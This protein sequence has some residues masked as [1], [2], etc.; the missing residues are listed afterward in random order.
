M[1]SSAASRV[2]GKLRNRIAATRARVTLAIHAELV[3][4]NPVDT[5]H[6]RASWVPSL[7]APAGAIGSR[8][9]VSDAAAAA[10]A[11]VVAASN[12]PRARAFVTNNAHYIGYLN[13]GRSK[14]APAGFVQAAVKRG[15]ASVAAG[16]RVVNVAVRGPK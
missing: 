11:S 7:D 9:V 12:D 13:K 14:Q 16:A 2:G 15:L 6:A 5:G 1:A 4:A 8:D 10:G 3:E